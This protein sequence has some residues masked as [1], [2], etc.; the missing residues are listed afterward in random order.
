MVD[1][2]L[3]RDLTRPP[4]TQHAFVLR[5]LPSRAGRL[6]AFAARQR[7]LVLCYSAVSPATARQVT[8]TASVSFRFRTSRILCVFLTMPWHCR[9]S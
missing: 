7:R 2:L 9:W 3:V 4:N 8:N 6:Y 5:P 1:G